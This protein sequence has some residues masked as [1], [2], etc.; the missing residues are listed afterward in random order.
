MGDHYFAK[1]EV[2]TYMAFLQ[3]TLPRHISP[4]KK[5]QAHVYLKQVDMLAI[6]TQFFSPS[7]NIKSSWEDALLISH[8]TERKKKKPI[9]RGV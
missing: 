9:P 5:L 2:H 8:K 6:K 1:V 4:M 3:A 7:L